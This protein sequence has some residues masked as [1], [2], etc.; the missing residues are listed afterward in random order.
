MFNYITLAMIKRYI[1]GAINDS[2]DDRLNDF[3]AWAARLVEWWKGRRFDVR[4]ETRVFDTP[5]A[6]GSMFGVYDARL[7]AGASNP[8]LRLDD[9]LL[10]VIELKNGDGVAIPSTDYVLEP[11]NVYPKNR[12]RLRSGEIWL[13]SD[14]GP[15]Q[16]IT[17]TGLW[18]NHE[19]YAEAWRAVDTVQVANM[20][21]GDVLINITNPA[22]YEVGQLLK[23][24]DEFMLLEE[25]DAVSKKLTVERA[26][27]G[28]SAAAHALA[29]P[30]SVFQTSGTIS[31]VC[32]RLVKWRYAQKD[33]DNFDQSY[34]LGSGVVSTPT[35]IPA[36][37][38][39]ILGA[40]RVR[41]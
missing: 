21:I 29:T 25:I 26:V 16:A 28:T 31:Q 39:R 13:K 41:L 18:G 5:S 4:R 11:A 3:L 6:G 38:A 14:D 27:N 35:S 32:M 37:V 23:L 9:D 22:D 7:L 30:I 36:D 24:E 20:L 8:V 15:E 2:D 10:A 34:V 19:R 1:G 33:V 17:L 40:Q 12:I